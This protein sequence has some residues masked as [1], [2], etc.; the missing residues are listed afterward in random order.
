M[1]EEEES[2]ITVTVRQP[3]DGDGASTNNPTRPPKVDPYLTEGV[4]P[5][6]QAHWDVILKLYLRT[7]RGPNAVQDLKM[8]LEDY[9]VLRQSGH[10]GKGRYVRYLPRGLVDVDLKRGGWVVKCN[11]TSVHLQD[12]RRQWRVL[13]REHFIFVRDEH[14]TEPV[15]RHHRKNLL[16]LLAEE[17]LYQD[18]KY[19]ES[20]RRREAPDDSPPPPRFKANFT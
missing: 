4:V 5:I 7:Y 6:T 17:T 8:Q 3:N 16:R 19:K 14:A 1:E 2:V 11:S 10:V 20:I 15:N 12:G 9:K 13:R 18:N